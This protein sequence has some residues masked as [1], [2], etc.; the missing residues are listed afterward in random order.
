MSLPYKISIDKRLVFYFIMPYVNLQYKTFIDERL[1][2]YAITRFYRNNKHYH[3]FA[4]AVGDSIKYQGGHIMRIV[5][6]W[7]HFTNTV[8]SLGSV[9]A[10]TMSLT[11][12]TFMK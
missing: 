11:S 7:E 10:Q 8:D 5:L 3:E 4:I 2:V 6:P 9:S 12:S 1:I